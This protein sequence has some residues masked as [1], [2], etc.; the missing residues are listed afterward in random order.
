MSFANQNEREF[1][2][3]C[4]LNCVIHMDP[5]CGHFVEPCSDFKCIGV[6]IVDY[7]LSFP[8]LL[9]VIIVIILILCLLDFVVHMM[10]YY[11]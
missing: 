9:V 10:C 4:F 11:C 6:D 7:G 8:R 5:L 2:K 3:H 1:W